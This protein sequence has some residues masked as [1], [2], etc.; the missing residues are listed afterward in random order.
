MLDILKGAMPATHALHLHN[1]R[2][3]LHVINSIGFSVKRHTGVSD[4]FRQVATVCELL[5]PSAREF[6]DFLC[7]NARGR[8]IYGAAI[9]IEPPCAVR[10]VGMQGRGASRR[11]P[12]L[13]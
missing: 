6:S 10:E 8:M 1:G 2:W 3:S 9:V 11:A 7:P 13:R 5:G 4:H 12:F